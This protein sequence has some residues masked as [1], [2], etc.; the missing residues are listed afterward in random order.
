MITPP[1]TG[2]AQVNAELKRRGPFPDAETAETTANQ[3]L[4]VWR[5]LQPGSADAYA[6]LV[7]ARCRRQA[8]RK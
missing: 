3:L 1:L 6:T 4:A 8:E 5:A 7:M 2:V